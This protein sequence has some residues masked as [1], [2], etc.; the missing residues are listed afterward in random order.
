MTTVPGSTYGYVQVLVLTGMGDYGSRVVAETGSYGYDY[1]R[2]RVVL[3]LGS[4]CSGSLRAQVLM[5]MGSYG[6]R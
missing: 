1:L 6:S 2:V 4:W 5:G 3:G